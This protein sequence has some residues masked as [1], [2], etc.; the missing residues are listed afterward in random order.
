MGVRLGEAEQR[1]LREVVGDGCFVFGLGSLLYAFPRP[2][3]SI[4]HPGLTDGQYGIRYASD[5]EPVGE[6]E[7]DFRQPLP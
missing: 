4:K 3:L 7:S 2:I 1:G 6:V 5:F